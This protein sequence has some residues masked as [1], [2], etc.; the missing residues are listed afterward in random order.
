MAKW[1]KLCRYHCECGDIHMLQ[2]M[3]FLKNISHLTKVWSLS[4]SPVWW[5]FSGM[6]WHLNQF[7]S[8]AMKILP[9]SLWTVNTR[10]DWCLLLCC[11]HWTLTPLLECTHTIGDS[12]DQSSVVQ[13]WL[14]RANCSLSWQPLWSSAAEAQLLYSSGLWAFKDALQHTLLGK[15]DCL[16]Y[17]RLPVWNI[18]AC[19][20]VPSHLNLL[21]SSF[22][23]SV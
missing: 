20:Y 16:S 10:Q 6:L 11:L 7:Q 17:I 15:S 2:P 21:S 1:P 12:S 23:V 3:F 14:A 19:M 13:F 5:Q 9:T 18:R 8:C 4:D 22:F